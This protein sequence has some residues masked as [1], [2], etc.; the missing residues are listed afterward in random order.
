MNDEIFVE[1]S[2]HHGSAVHFS[3]KNHG[4]P[5]HTLAHGSGEISHQSCTS[6][7]K[8]NLHDSR[9]GK[10]GRG[11]LDMF[12]LDFIPIL[13]QEL[14]GAGLSPVIGIGIGKELVSGYDLLLGSNFWSLSV[15][16]GVHL[17]QFQDGLFLD[18]FAYPCSLFFR[19]PGHLDDD[20]V[21]PLRL[22][23]HVLGPVRVQSPPECLDRLLDRIR[24]DAES[25]SV[26]IAGFL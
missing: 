14:F 4:K 6:I 25:I 3:I 18:D 15:I 24:G 17:T 11:S 1:D 19:D 21:L 5:V 7:G 9:R 22:D 13:E 26:C 23:K 8:S 20:H 16:V 2:L 10:I 12:P